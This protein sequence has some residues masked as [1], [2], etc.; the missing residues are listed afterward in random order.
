M[1]WA[2]IWRDDF[3]NGAVDLSTMNTS[4]NKR[5]TEAG[6]RLTIAVDAGTNA[7]WWM[8]TNNTPIA[9]KTPLPSSVA[10]HRKRFTTKTDVWTTGASNDS[11]VGL[12][13]FLNNSNAYRLFYRTS[14]GS[15]IIQ[16]EADI[17]GSSRLLGVFNK[18]VVAPASPGACL[19]LRVMWCPVHSRVTFYYAQKASL[20]DDSDY[21]FLTS[22]T[23]SQFIPDRVGLYNKTYGV[24]PATSA[25]SDWIVAEE[26]D[27]ACSCTEGWNTTY[28]DDFDDS[29]LSMWTVNTAVGK[30]VTE[31]ASALTVN[32]NAGSNSDLWTGIYNCTL[33]YIS[34]LP[35]LSAH[36][37]FRY[38]AKITGYTGVDKSTSE[39]IIGMMTDQ[40]NI[41]YAGIANAT[42]WLTQI[43]ICHG[44]V[45]G[46]AYGQGSFQ[47]T[48]P[49]AGLPLYVRVELHSDT[50]DLRFYVAQKATEPTDDDYVLF[51]TIGA[52]TL[53]SYLIL[54]TKNWGAFPAVALTCDWV[55]AEECDG[56]PIA[57][58][59]PLR[60]PSTIF[61][62]LTLGK[63]WGTHRLENANNYYQMLDPGIRLVAKGTVTAGDFESGSGD[64]TTW[65]GLRLLGAYCV[66]DAEYELD[67]AR[68]YY[69]AGASGGA[70]GF[71]FA[72]P[73]YAAR[74]SGTSYYHQ[75]TCHI[76]VAVYRK[77]IGGDFYVGLLSRKSGLNF[78][79]V[80]E[81]ICN[82]A[83]LTIKLRRIESNVF[84]AYYN[85]GAG[86]VLIGTT[87]EEQW[88]ER[89][90]HIDVGFFITP[91]TASRYEYDITA[92]RQLSG[93]YGVDYT[94]D[95]PSDSFLDGHFPQSK[96]YTKLGGYH[97]AGVVQSSSRYDT[98]QRLQLFEY[99][100]GA[101]GLIG[102]HHNVQ[103]WG[104]GGGT[105]E[106]YGN[107]P[108][109]IH[110]PWVVF[111]G[112][113]DVEAVLYLQHVYGAG[114]GN[115]YGQF[116]LCVVDACQTEYVKP[117]Y[118]TGYQNDVGNR[119][120]VG[121]RLDVLGAVGT[122]YV[123]AAKP[124]NAGRTDVNLGAGTTVEV[125]V[126]ITRS[127]AVLRAYY[128]T[129]G[130]WVQ[131]GTDWT[132]AVSWGTW[133]HVYFEAQG[134][135]YNGAAPGGRV[136]EITQVK[137]IKW[138]S[139]DYE[140]DADPPYISNLSPFDTEINVAYNATVD[141]DI[142]DITSGVDEPSI[143]V[144]VDGVAAWSG[145]TQQPGFTVTET[146]VANGYRFHIV[147][148]V[149]F[150]Y[151]HHGTLRFRAND[152][153]GNTLDQTTTFDTVVDLDAPILQNL[154]P[155]SGAVGVSPTTSFSM[156]LIDLVSGVV[157]VQTIIDIRGV[158][159]Y[160][161]G[162]GQPS[163]SVLVVPILFGYRYV[164]TPLF[165]FAY[166]ELV[167]IRVRAIDVAGNTLDQTYYVTIAAEGQQYIAPQTNDAF[168][169]A[170]DFPLR[171]IA[172]CNVELATNEK[173][174]AN[175]MN[176]CALLAI[177]SLPLK[178]DIG[179]TVPSGVFDQNDLAAVIAWKQSALTA[180]QK[181]EPRVIVDPNIQFVLDDSGN[182]VY[183]L[184][185]YMYRSNNEG[186]KYTLEN[187]PSI[188][189]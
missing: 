102:S 95:V 111:A 65:R 2:E 66:D 123:C 79:V 152:Y 112:D 27:T 128:Y 75:S 53:P 5:I 116:N 138:N 73:H 136:Y 117:M 173:A 56:T 157:D 8:G 170:I 142:L 17:A 97:D 115:S 187:D 120:I 51:A 78:T 22:V 164:V 31:A 63:Q 69:D 33:A 155:V 171:F 6:T 110:L 21:K 184:F 29:V 121:V 3:D 154:N 47:A 48:N 109:G 43:S 182:I 36:R 15:P 10:T 166:L 167:S 54:G 174:I 84:A 38:T 41:Y 168:L 49:S 98:A 77:V 180:I 163:F 106:Y 68:H 165:S 143:I 114:G 50:W 91:T 76:A 12:A 172:D 133:L 135:L 60:F 89:A 92:F 61:P 20:P 107:T 149:N 186:W 183:I 178:T 44:N 88:T 90:L 132:D 124:F 37:R 55:K 13:F 93:T 141:V 58:T 119:Y 100:S 9:Y 30:T 40:N 159:A 46:Y 71:A 189:R 105:P 26:E 131:I 96:I 67:V 32:V 7:D 126:R 81:S 153:Y 156:E 45:D 1:A 72:V 28:F 134:L 125:R 82:S 101:A 158:A 52:C 14:S 150:G 160:T 129:G 87:Y 139:G 62:G 122:K 179:S 35:A 19:Y 42:T 34:V 80:A 83:S 148:S 144:D 11:Q 104:I 94:V 70:F 59:Y 64:A 39:L 162:A 25:G 108:Y 185:N 85:V 176:L 146:P 16:L 188:A 175:G 23:T 140:L 151:N 127:G 118:T 57:R 18:N 86:D 145:S 169:T 177:N 147:P 181:Y 99:S 137:E 130:A 24:L 113:F 4:A 103:K 161:G 74:T